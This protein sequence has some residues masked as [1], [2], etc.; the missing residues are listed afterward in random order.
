LRFLVVFPYIVAPSMN[1]GMLVYPA[2]ISVTH[3][4]FKR[5]T[6]SCWS[7]LINFDPAFLDATGH[8][9][10]QITVEE[11]VNHGKGGYSCL[12][13]NRAGQ[14]ASLV[15]RLLEAL[16]F[17]NEDR[18]LH[19][20]ASTFGPD[21]LRIHAEIMGKMI[22]AQDFI[23]ALSKV[24]Y[25]IIEKPLPD[26]LTDELIDLQFANAKEKVLKSSKCCDY[27]ERKPPNHGSRQHCTVARATV[28]I[29]AVC[30]LCFSGN[31]FN[32][33][34]LYDPEKHLV[35][36]ISVESPS[37]QTGDTMS[38]STDEVPRDERAEAGLD[39]SGMPIINSFMNV[40]EAL[41]L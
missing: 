18:A 3:Y 11:N 16:H 7:S 20:L 17:S 32:F 41:F 19:F 26:Y 28:L 10:H 24:Y 5:G 4:T 38:N 14:Y 23:S 37:L 40:D 25:D 15:R 9:F 21:Q 22:T 12:S 29:T 31:L 36:S 13:P 27:H 35:S 6:I 2:E 39:A 34:D 33:R 30:T 1:E 8:L